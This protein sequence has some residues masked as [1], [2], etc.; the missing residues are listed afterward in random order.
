MSSFYSKEH[1]H[2]FPKQLKEHAPDQLKAFNEFNMKVFKDGALTRKEKE[3]V[4]VATTHVTQ[5]PYCIESHTKNAKKAGATLEELTEAAFVTAAVE[6]GSAVTHST[7][8][9]NA[10][11]K[12]APDSLY[13]RSNLKHLN[14][15]NK[16]AGES[17]KGY[18]AFSDAATKAGKLSTKFKEIIA[19]AVAHATQ[20]PYCIDVHTKS[21]EREGATSEELAEAIMVTAALRAGGSY[22]H[23]RIMF[24]SYQE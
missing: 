19:V 9:H 2:D 20:C 17:F 21:A 12:E 18:Q 23:M 11:D 13:Q 8:V 3:L 15:L 22:A 14:E 5:C 6:A 10:T 24:D 7:H 4:A 1:T 16:L